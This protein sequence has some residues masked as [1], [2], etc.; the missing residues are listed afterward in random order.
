MYSVD[1]DGTE[2]ASLL[3]S[4]ED[5]GYVCNPDT[6]DCIRAFRGGGT[7]RVVDS[8]VVEHRMQRRGFGTHLYEMAAR[9][10]CR[11]G[12]PLVSAFRLKGA[13]SN[14]FWAKQR[15]KKRVAIVGRW[16]AGPGDHRP[17]FAFDCGKGVDLSG[18]RN[19]RPKG[20]KKRRRSRR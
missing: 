12:E 17:I 14:D 15:A 1:C 7:I 18:L 6:V 3:V 16:R 8:I 10:A 19:K 9:D 2:V 5:T 13:K 11:A 4:R 20:P